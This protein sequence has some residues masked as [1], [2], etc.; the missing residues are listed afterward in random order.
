MAS[1]KT[2]NCRCGVTFKTHGNR[3]GH[4]SGRECHRTFDG[5]KAFDRHQ[6]ITDGKV[7]CHDP[8][9]MTVADGRAM[10]EG[11]EI[12]G[13]TYWRLVPSE[14]QAER[15]AALCA[16]RREARQIPAEQGQVASEGPPD[17]EEAA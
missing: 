8:A 17:T 11:R 2:A 9:N 5:L 14:E 6:T 4:C 1:P 13:V 10:Y 15:W 16:E 3:T 7:T 12:D